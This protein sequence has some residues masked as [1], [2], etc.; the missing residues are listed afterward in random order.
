MIGEEGGRVVQDMRSVGAGQGF[1]QGQSPGIGAPPPPPNEYRGAGRHKKDLEPR[2]RHAAVA[3]FGILFLLSH[4]IILLMFFGSPY[5]KGLVNEGLNDMLPFIGLYLFI[6]VL[7]TLMLLSVFKRRV[8]HGLA[9][10]VLVYKLCSIFVPLT[11]FDLLYGV[12]TLGEGNV[13]A[14]II[15]LSF[16]GSTDSLITRVVDLICWCAPFAVYYLIM[17]VRYG[18]HRPR[19][20]EG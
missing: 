20:A 17:A 5:A 14:W 19:K 4:T 13:I 8:F 2:L 7:G 10:F 18:R 16:G 12:G 1:D 3:A 9:A 11:S 6:G 15:T